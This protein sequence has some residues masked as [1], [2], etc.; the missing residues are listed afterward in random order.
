MFSF[1]GSG[2][3]FPAMAGILSTMTSTKFTS[4]VLDVKLRDSTH[5]YRGGLRGELMEGIRMFD[6]PLCR[7]ATRKTT[8]K[9]AFVIV[10]ADDPVPLTQGLVQFHQVGDIW[11][12]QNVGRGR[13]NWFLARAG[14]AGAR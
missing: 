9:R 11:A 13:Y 3:Q 10:F 1:Y 7:L 8:P 6:P 12:G 2:A 14:E 4:L 5:A